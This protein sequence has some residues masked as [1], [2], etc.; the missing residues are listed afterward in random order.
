MKQEVLQRFLSYVTIDTQSNPYSETLPST[1][2]QNDLAD[3]LYKELVE[4]GASNVRKSKNCYVYA[5]IP[6]TSTG[7]YTLGFIAHM[8]TAPDAP[9]DLK[10]P[11]VIEKYDGKDIE[12]SKETVLTTKE[13]PNL[14]EHVGKTVVC[15]DGRCLLGGDD[16]A[17]VAIIMTLAQHLLNHPEIPHGKITIAFTPDEE[18]GR[19]VEG[20]EVEAFNTDGAYTIDGGGIGELEYENFNAAGV[21]IVV[22]GKSIHPGYAKDLMI[23]ALSVAV[24]LD[25]LLPCFE[26][27][28]HTEGYQGF[29]HLTH[30]DGNVEKANVEY[31]IRDHDK[32]KFEDRKVLMQ[33]AVDS[34]NQKYGQGTV[35]LYMKDSYFNMKE[36]ILQ[37][38]HLVENAKKAFLSQGITPQINPIR[39]GTDGATL[40]FKGLPCPNLSG[41]YYNAHGRYEYAVVDDMANMVKVCIELAKLYNI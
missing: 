7:K 13:F 19:G 12:L 9:G 25:N 28:Q 1:Q 38:F 35:E 10:I 4:M 6:A 29:F 16:K 41:C 40:S 23:N 33:Q 39:G 21:K 3:L 20:F 5:E 37:H 32:Q 2:K 26:R 34:L 17:G 30:L 14:L 27:P 24:E 36:I 11:T 15:A 31:I 22:N 18:V 8:D